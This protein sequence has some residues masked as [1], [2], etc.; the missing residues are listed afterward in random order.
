MVPSSDSCLDDPTARSA[1]SE[2]PTGGAVSVAVASG[3]NAGD[4]EPA[5]LTGARP[6]RRKGLPHEVADQLLEL[7][8]NSGSPQVTLPSERQLGDD[9]AVS[10]NVLREALAALDHMGVVE[11]RGKKRI[12]DTSRARALL[13][14]RASTQP[15]E[16][17]LLLDPIEV[18]RILEPESAALAAKRASDQ[19]IRE[20]KHTIDLMDAGVRRGESVIEYDSAFHIAIARATANQILIELVG[21]LG[22]ALRP[23]REL[24]F[25]PTEASRA[26]LEDHRAILEAI[27]AGDARAARRAMRSHLDHVEDLIRSTVSASSAHTG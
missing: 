27:Q 22:E 13:L 18:R 12:G 14:A 24:S 17:E 1:L 4:P 6:A 26:A 9:L 5:R 11:T 19:S 7:I 23:S 20:I 16:R 2:R 25:R 15:P 10:R 3:S 8:A 21:A